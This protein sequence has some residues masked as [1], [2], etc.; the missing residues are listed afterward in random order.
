MSNRIAAMLIAS[1]VCTVNAESFYTDYGDKM[2]VGYTVDDVTDE[3]SDVLLHLKF[4]DKS[5]IVFACNE[6][7]K[8]AMV[9]INSIFDDGGW[10]TFHSRFDKDEPFKI[11][12]TGTT[13]MTLFFDEGDSKNSTA[14]RKRFLSGLAS[15]DKFAANVNFRHHDSSKPSIDYKIR[16][17]TKGGNEAVKKYRELCDERNS[18]L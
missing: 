16:I 11:H 15:S 7:N 13:D 10:F 18:E 6:G 4:T 5:S 8:E 2:R 1:S 17:S 12:S 3:K 14:T 9:S